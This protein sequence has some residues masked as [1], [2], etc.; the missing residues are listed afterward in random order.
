MRRVKHRLW[1]LTQGEHLRPLPPIGPSEVTDTTVHCG[2]FS[3]LGT[4]Q[5]HSPRLSSQMSQ[6]RYTRPRLHCSDG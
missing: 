3:E 4:R 6:E 5:K 1:P 2:A